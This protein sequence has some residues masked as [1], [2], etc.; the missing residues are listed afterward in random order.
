VWE[1]VAEEAEAV[2]TVA[3]VWVAAPLAL[4]VAE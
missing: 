4:A 1:A 3:A 2:A